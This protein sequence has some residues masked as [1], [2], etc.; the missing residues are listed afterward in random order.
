ML[1]AKGI[2]MHKWNRAIRVIEDNVSSC[3]RQQAGGCSGGRQQT[4]GKWV[5]EAAGWNK[6]VYAASSR[7]DERGIGGESGGAAVHGFRQIEEA[8]SPSHN[9]VVQQTICRSN[10]RLP[11]VQRRLEGTSGLAILF[12]KQ[13]SSAQVC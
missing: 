6:G 13:Q 11:V 10:S 1:H 3:K 9:G 5:A 12:Y 2:R 7:G 8:I 4:A